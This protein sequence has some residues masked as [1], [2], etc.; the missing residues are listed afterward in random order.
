M[1]RRYLSR[2]GQPKNGVASVSTRPSSSR[3][4]VE[5]AAGALSARLMPPA[6]QL[7]YTLLY[8]IV[9]AVAAQSSSDEWSGPSVR[10]IHHQTEPGGG[11]FLALEIGQQQ[12]LPHTTTLSPPFWLTLTL[13]LP[14]TAAG[15]PDDT[16]MFD[17]QIRRAAAAGLRLVCICL[18]PD[19]YPQGTRPGASPW[20]SDTS[21]LD[22]RTRRLL[23]R[24]L[25]LHPTALFIIRFYAQQP[26]MLMDTVL[27][28]LTDDGRVDLYNVTDPRFRGPGMMN[29][30]T[31]EWERSAAAKL[32]LMLRYLDRVYPRRIAGVFPT[33]LHT[34]EWFM[35]GFGYDFAPG[36]LLVSDYSEGMRQRYC[37][38]VDTRPNCSLP[39]PSWR[40]RAVFGDGFAAREVVALNLFYSGVVASAIEA[41]VEAA[42]QACD[43]KCMTL[44]YYGYHF[45]LAGSRL[46]GSGHLALTRLLSSPHLDAVVSPY[47][48]QAFVRN[49]SRGAPMTA[50]GPWDSAAAH[51][52]FWVIE[53]DSRTVLDPLPGNIKYSYTNADTAQLLRRNML[54]ALMHS[55]ALYF[56]DLNHA[57]YFG[58]PQYPD[59]TSAIWDS[60]ATVVN[61]F[62]RLVQSNQSH[63]LANSHQVVRRLHPQIAVFSDES[64]AA[65]RTFARLEDLPTTSSPSYGAFDTLLLGSST[66]VLGSTGAAVRGFQMT[67][68]LVDRIPPIDWSQFKLC[69]FLNAFVLTP[70]VQSAIMSKLQGTHSNCTVVFQYAAGLFNDTSAEANTSRVSDIVQM[71]LARGPGGIDLEIT[72]ASGLQPPLDAMAGLRYGHRGCCGQWQSSV[73]PWFHLD[74]SKT[75]ADTVEVLGTLEHAPNAELNAGLLR[76]RNKATGHITIFSAAPGLPVRLWRGLAQA[77]GV[78]LFTEQLPIGCVASN[79]ELW[80]QPLADSVEVT[81]GGMLLY[82]AASACLQTADGLM[83]RHVALPFAARVL[84]ES[85]MTVCEDCTSFVTPPMAAGEVRLYSVQEATNGNRKPAAPPSTQIWEPSFPPMAP[86]FAPDWRLNAS[87][88][89]LT[90]N[91]SGWTDTAS[92][93]KYGIIGFGTHIHTAVH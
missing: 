67:D 86:P 59:A 37:A 42:K 56:Y 36:E 4:R 18:T 64:S 53:D 91:I 46:P 88:I 68:L 47:T 57:G 17:E 31:L 82:H 23:D 78:H 6:M 12:Q 24:V 11:G 49:N 72:I 50:H 62:K 70:A 43:G 52:K 27:L 8:S 44:A 90:G 55:S 51:G 21:P 13:S 19:N 83:A 48:Y 93:A 34:A 84:N 87:T 71:P 30:L 15:E 60:V 54:T 63:A 1:T 3:G 9:P 85:N 2:E 25:V 10:P 41:L 28:N 14:N 39:L 45:E 80:I 29:S 89:I 77:S 69:V 92:A 61:V 74:K 73:N 79:A 22:N 58:N 66:A 20:F 26:D 38:D 35:P 76:S 33:F 75:T 40:N 16:S 32:R 81:T 5:K 65:T 7:L